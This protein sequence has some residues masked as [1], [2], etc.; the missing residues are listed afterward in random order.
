MSEWLVIARREFIER[1]RTGWFVVVTVLGP[2]AMV[3]LMVV[4]AWLGERSASQRIVIQVVD[5][6]GHELVPGLVSEAAR[7]GANLDLQPVAAD[8]D[9]ELLVGRIRDQSINGF[10]TIP[11]GALAGEP[12]VYRGD[13]A[14]N[15]RIRG[16]LIH[17]LNEAAKAVRARAAGIPDET[18]AS[19]GRPPIDV[20]ARH[21]T[22][23]G[24]TTSGEASFVAGFA[25]MFILYMSILLY[26]VNVMRSV[27]QE[28]T[29]R[30]VEIVVS[31]IKPRALMLGKVIGVGSVGLLQLG[32]WAV[33]ALVMV[34]LRVE[35]LGLFGITGSSFDLPP[36]DAMDVLVILAYFALG[37]FLYAALYAAIGAMVNSE[38]EAQQ[39][40]TPVILLLI[41]PIAC[42]Q[43]VSNDPRSGAAQL[44]TMVPF[45]S[46][47]L[48]PMRYL[49]GGATWSEVGLSLLLLV[50]SIAVA[51]AVAARIYRVGIL[52]Y[53]KRPSLRELARWIRYS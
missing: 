50:A 11:P 44:L 24:G 38:Q 3:A 1:V 22:G 5:R 41:V 52:M 12:A 51:V 43:M 10:L 20:V 53:G 4:P 13:N 8:I 16:T 36:L 9:D 49:L 25:V 46:P 48:M 28:K 7:V 27:I 2:V 30:V 40:Q 31:A 42:V 47:V 34:A 35:I 19:L 15:L 26:A 17:A 6:S 37:Y 21:D 23:R 39:L 32:I 18:L 14:T 29:S 33:V 45:S